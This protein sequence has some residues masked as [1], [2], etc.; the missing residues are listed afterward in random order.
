MAAV[1]PRLVIEKDGM[2]QRLRSEFAEPSTDKVAALEDVAV[3]EGVEENMTVVE[4]IAVA[5]GMK[6]NMT[7]VELMG[8]DMTVEAMEECMTVRARG[9]CS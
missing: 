1:A 9:H 6:E 8:A 5:E 2:F 7:V 4:A 3:A